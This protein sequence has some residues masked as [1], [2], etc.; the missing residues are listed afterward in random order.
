[1]YTGLLSEDD[2]EKGNKFS[3]SFQEEKGKGSART[4][5]IVD[6]VRF[7]ARK[8]IDFPS[9]DRFALRAQR[10]IAQ[11][12]SQSDGAR[13][14]Q[15]EALSN[16]KGRFSS[17][18]KSYPLGENGWRGDY[19][20]KGWWYTLSKPWDEIPFKLESDNLLHDTLQ[21]GSISQSSPA[22]IG[23]ADLSLRKVISPLSPGANDES[24]KDQET[25]FQKEIN[26]TT[27]SFS[28]PRSMERKRCRREL[29]NFLS[30][31]LLHGKKWFLK[32]RLKGD[33][34]LGIDVLTW[35][36]ISSTHSVVIVGANG[37]SH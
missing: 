10:D 32:S 3:F 19:Q 1:M 21:W 28:P 15:P 35:L 25:D 34:C 26:K 31:M 11:F 12:T 29:T 24:E 18:S 22:S 17:L 14:R 5:R 37:F 6:S 8:E 13:R 9:V 27:F 23:L 7:F 20:T 4:D 16:R 36:E 30:S 2:V 33:Q